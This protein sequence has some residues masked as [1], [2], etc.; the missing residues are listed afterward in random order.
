[1]CKDVA[2]ADCFARA[3]GFHW[4]EITDDNDFIQSKML[5][6][7]FTIFPLLQMNCL[8]LNN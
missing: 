7:Y 6:W 3:K 2:K 4:E 5:D 1:M 8:S